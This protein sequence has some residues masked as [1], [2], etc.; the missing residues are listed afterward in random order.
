MKLRHAVFAGSGR[1]GLYRFGFKRLFRGLAFHGAVAG[2]LVCLGLRTCLLLGMMAVAAPAKAD[3]RFVCNPAQLPMLEK[4]MLEYLGK[5]DIDPALVTQSEQQDTGAVAYALATP[6][7][8]TDTLDLVRRVEYK[9][10]LE[11]VQLPVRGGKLRK[12][13][14]VSKKEILL[15]VL[16]HGRTTSFD[17]DACSLGALE[18]HIGLRQN[19]V[20]WTEVLQWTWPDGGRARWNVRYWANGVP[21]NGVSTAAA[22]MDAFQSQNKYAIGCYTAAK[23]LMAQGVVDYFQRVR[24]DASRELGVERRLA[25]D[26]D[27]LVDVEP[28]RMW[29]FE[30]EFDPATL[31]RPGKLLRIAEQV[32]PRN[33]I[34]GDWAYF[35]NTD[36]R[37]SQKTGY[38]GSNAIYLGRGKFGDFYNDNHHAY[39]FDQKLDEV[40]Q[41]RNGV[42]SRSRDFRKIQEMSAQ[43][44]ERLARTPE[45]GGLVLDIRATPQLFG[46]ETLPPPAAR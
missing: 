37:S 22:L 39:T 26:G 38:E 15:S 20:A 30:K 44:Y 9:V 35:V 43:D 4:Q 18:E 6:A 45:E 46:Y 13:A 1:P 5:L 33:F 12:V 25:L 31:P 41:W 42:F 36:P 24:P 28:P 14:T 11:S 34:P 17:D 8:D 29:S 10:P 27:P 16:Q 19:I 40:Y 2:S 23:L 21:R 3:L 32:A 7:D